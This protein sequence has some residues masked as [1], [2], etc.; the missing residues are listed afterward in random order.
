MTFDHAEV[1]E[2]ASVRENVVREAIRTRGWDFATC[3]H[4]CAVGSHAGAIVSSGS[5]A[6]A[7][8]RLLDLILVPNYPSA[9]RLETIAPY[10]GPDVLR[11]GTRTEYD[12]RRGYWRQSIDD[13]RR[14]IAVEFDQALRRFRE[15]QRERGTAERK[16]A[17]SLYAARATFQATVNTL[18]L[19]GIDPELIPSG[20]GVAADVARAAWSSIERSLPVLTGMRKDLWIDPTE[21]RANQTDHARDL[22]RRIEAALETVFGRMPRERVVLHHGFYF[23]TPPQWA[24]FRLL[25]ACGVRQVFIV[26]D[27]GRNQAFDV[28]RR[29]FEPRWG[30]VNRRRERELKHRPT[31]AAEI[32][33]SAMTAERIDPSAAGGLQVRRFENTADLAAEMMRLRGEYDGAT[34][35]PRLFAAEERLIARQIARLAAMADDE[36]VQLS[37]LPVGVFLLRVHEAISATSEGVVRMRLRPEAVRDILSTG[38]LGPDIDQ[39]ALVVRLY[40][41]ASPFFEDCEHPDDW[42]LRAKHLRG[43]IETEVDRIEPR[44]S[45]DGT[46]DRVN[47][48]AR[49]P[50]RRAPWLDL[51]VPESKLLHEAIQRTTDAI[52]RFAAE[53]QIGLREHMRLVTALLDRTSVQLPKLE[54]EVLERRLQRFATGPVQSVDSE[55]LFDLMEVILASRLPSEDDDDDGQAVLPL[56]SLLTLGF[57]PSKAPIL[58]TNLA[59]GAFPAKVHPVPWPFSIDGLRG[60]AVAEEAVSLL[61]LRRET[62]A[63]G[64]LYLLWLALD[65]VDGADVTLSWLA[66]IDGEERQMS[67][68]L[69]ILIRDRHERVAA[70]IG[71][72]DEHRGVTSG[73]VPGE[74]TAVQ[75]DR[76]TVDDEIERAL[77]VLE[78]GVLASSMYCARRFALQWLVGPSASFRAPHHHR[79]LYGNV[80]GALGLLGHLR[81][82]D[83]LALCNDLWRHLTPAERESSRVNRRIKRAGAHP[84]WLLTLAGSSTG[85]DQASR[86]Y[87]IAKRARDIAEDDLSRVTDAVST[88]KVL[89]P[90]SPSVTAEDCARCPVR[91]RCLQALYQDW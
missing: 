89:P 33:V 28:W 36:E 30:F 62:G 61:D 43:L 91:S 74:E 54:R 86:S 1:I 18:A 24:L 13:I 64:D 83:A 52:R 56:R 27:D 38:L 20:Q 75:I 39:L 81:R 71:G 31:K 88:D 84:T 65:G 5:P 57:A 8:A 55:G 29:F 78:P 2:V 3:G 6:I 58:V 14:F 42:D 70:V 90:R 77:K 80:I 41:L 60:A 46:V 23:F 25:D 32:L 87:Q 73:T 7:I 50:L 40:D 48:S 63:L 69:Q 82:D 34:H 59:D 44:E 4:I 66:R 47:K 37:T 76:D 79:M 85:T 16:A 12:R 22:R 68:L 19:S 9:Y 11:H 17:E 10:P 21:L 45:T 49:N 72:L 26:H 51:S 35:R 15:T 53:P 67:A